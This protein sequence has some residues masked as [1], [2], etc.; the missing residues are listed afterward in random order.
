[1]GRVLGGGRSNRA[2]GGTQRT[3]ELR[4]RTEAVNEQ[5]EEF[6]AEWEIDEEFEEVVEMV[7]RAEGQGADAEGELLCSAYERLVYL[8]GV[9]DARNGFKQRM[10]T[11]G[12]MISWM[13]CQ[14]L[15]K[16]DVLRFAIMYKARKP[17][18]YVHLETNKAT[19]VDPRHCVRVVVAEFKPDDEQ[20]PSLI[21][22][23]QVFLKARRNQAEV[24]REVEVWQ[25]LVREYCMEV[26]PVPE[27]IAFVGN[28]KHQRGNNLLC[29]FNSSQDAAL[30]AGRKVEMGSEGTMMRWHGVFNRRAKQ[31]MAGCNL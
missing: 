5:G 23:G 31:K 24:D 7:N 4:R 1:M 22:W 19:N 27:Q 3:E 9:R 11:L 2:A 18:S 15:N 12:G 21:R 30:V 26:L 6:D 20:I 8:R 25:W 17:F 28:S 13:A 14:S 29:V 10:D 16:Y